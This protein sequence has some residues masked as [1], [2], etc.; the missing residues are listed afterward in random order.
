MNSSINKLPPALTVIVPAY[1]AGNLLAGVIADMEPYLHRVWLVDDG[2]TD[3]CADGL[4][5]KITRVVTLDTNRGKGCALLKGYAKAIEDTNVQCVAVFDADGQHDVRDLPRLYEVF[6]ENEADYLVGERD[7]SMGYV[8]FR[9]RVGN[10]V[11]RIVSRFVLGTTLKDTQSGFRLVSRKYLD[12][13]LGTIVGGRYETEM[14]M[15]AM[16]VHGDFTVVSE[17]IRTIY[18]EGNTSSHFHVL[19]DSFLIYRTL[20]RIWIKNLMS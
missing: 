18:E 7:F 4:E 16:A 2:S 6:L 19:R 9:S 10:N 13:I 17:P 11:T 12:A 20:T 3:G 1:N 5:S 14:E 15:L 8:P